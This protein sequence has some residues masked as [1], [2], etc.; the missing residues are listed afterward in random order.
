MTELGDPVEDATLMARL[1]PRT[2]ESQGVGASSGAPL[3]AEAVGR[4]ARPSPGT[5]RYCGVWLRVGRT[6]PDAR[7]RHAVRRRSSVRRA[8][9]VFRWIVFLVRRR[10]RAAGK[11]PAPAV[12]S[13]FA[14][15][16]SRSRGCATP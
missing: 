12:E 13:L 7:I 16:P 11:S 9:N 4:P 14:E 8:A 1:V 2:L 10:A 3:L 5:D 15:A 6:F